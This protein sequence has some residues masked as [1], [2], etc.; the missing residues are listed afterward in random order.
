MTTDD[1]ARALAES[2][3]AGP[4]QSFDPASPR[5]QEL[6]ERAK[7]IAPRRRRGRPRLLVI[8]ALGT[9]GLAAAA[10]AFVNTREPD[11]VLTVVCFESEARQ[12]GF[13]AST[14][15]A[16]AVDACWK[17][18][19]AGKFSPTPSPSRL[20]ACV[21]SGG[22]QVFPGGP[23]TCARLG[24]PMAP[25]DVRAAKEL[26]KLSDNI[27]ASFYRRAGCISPGRARVLAR[28]A[29]D[30]AGLAE[31]DVV[32]REPYDAAR[33]CADV[34]IDEANDRLVLFPEPPPPG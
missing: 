25:E 10:A 26:V 7:A 15:K 24:A 14:Q 16:S 11:E 17:F 13:A 33:P 1:A 18:W 12:V 21:V 27:A 3:P 23:E 30:D 34:T 5:G 2:D 28:E 32:D 29:L 8:A 31:W 4:L 22:V 19:Q 9:A 20:V 6:L